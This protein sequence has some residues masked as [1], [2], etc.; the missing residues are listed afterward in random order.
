MSAENAWIICNDLIGKNKKIQLS[1]LV[2][3]SEGLVNTTSSRSKR[4]V[5]NKKRNTHLP[6]EN[7]QE[8]VSRV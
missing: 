2:T 4:I 1:F 8:N 6:V 5:H 3:L 7:K